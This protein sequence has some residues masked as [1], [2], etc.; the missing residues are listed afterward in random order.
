M[1]PA[2]QVSGAAADRS[3]FDE[4]AQVQF[5]NRPLSEVVVVEMF[6]GSGR[7]GASLRM[8]GFDAF[9]IDHIVS[10][11]A[12]CSVLQLDLCEPE[13]VKHF[14]ELISDPSVGYVHCAPPCGTASR[15]RD[16]QFPG[17]PPQLRSVQQPEGLP[18][19]ESVNAIRVEKAN[20]LYQVTLE[21]CKFCQSHDK[22][23]SVENP[24]RSY[25][26]LIPAWVSFLQQDHVLQT[27]F[28][29]CEYG[30]TR[31]KATLLVHNVPKFKELHRL[32]SGNHVHAGW[33]RTQGKWATSLETA[34]PCR[35]CKVMANLLK[36]H[37]LAMGCHSPPQQLSEAP[38]S[39]P[40]ARAL[41]GLQSRKRIAPLISE[42]RAIHSVEVP[43][44]LA[45]LFLSPGKKL[46]TDWRPGTHVSCQPPAQVLPAGSRV[47]RAHVVQGDVG[48]DDELQPNLTV[49][50]LARP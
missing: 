30:G 16:I 32:C 19:L 27:N 50:K 40:G 20:S 18:D 36:E 35:L 29:H 6:C 39:V 42:F 17:A 34:Y 48:M 28:H 1:P 26:W 14:W 10:K 3:S 12:A 11:R 21:V 5:A 8:E 2:P 46:L 13:S 38:A 7:L 47:L 45:S 31:K 22:Y 24:L 23:F 41:S 33:G 49:L 4:A 43:Q 15:A 9:G 44:A 37:F 25:L